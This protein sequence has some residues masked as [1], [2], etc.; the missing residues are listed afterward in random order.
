ME[1]SFSDAVAKD[2]F[3]Q[4][5]RKHPQTSIFQSVQW[6]AVKQEWEP[7]YTGVYQG[8][9][10]VAAA[11]VLIRRLPLGYTLFY[12]PRGPLMDYENQELIAYYLKKLAVVAKQWRAISIK[13]D[14]NI[15]IESRPLNKKTK[16]KIRDQHPMV[17]ALARLGVK[18]F[19]FNND[20]QGTSQPRYNARIYYDQVKETI[21][22]SKGFKDALKAEKRGIQLVR[23]TKEDLP[24]FVDILKFTEERKGI[25]L[26]NVEYFQRLYDA[27]S[28]DIYIVATALN[29]K[30]TLNKQELRYQEVL[31]K[32][33]KR[34]NPNNN[35]ELEEQKQSLEK[36][37]AFLQ[38][39]IK[40]NPETVYLSTMLAVR[41]EKTCEILYAGA[42]A[43]YRQ[44]LA[45]YL[46]FS[47]GIQW[48]AESGCEVCNLG[49]IEGS[50]KDGLSIYK[51][52][53][54]SNVDEYVGE[55]D[56]PINKLVYPIFNK[57]LPMA[58]KLL[59]RL[60]K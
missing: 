6:P 3:D 17:E 16:E 22:K 39:K 43:S 10:L 9:T 12:I 15:V 24:L 50:L 1:Y 55:F 41:Y 14:P 38:E 40:D 42:D 28:Q 52:Y 51:S 4:F 54:D 60:R 37:I 29:L 19:G 45:S 5:S 57:A 48:G 31:E 13:F 49:G 27:F 25:S 36:D 2:V 21:N 59:H 53:F 11:L 34:K 8:N 23:L 47:K 32:L 30:E 18:H 33:K 58:K 26:R 44:Y 20:L 7:L 56:Y 46:S 35:H